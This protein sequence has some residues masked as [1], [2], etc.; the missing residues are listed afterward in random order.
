MALHRRGQ[1]YHFA[2]MVGGQRY[3]GST[4]ETVLSRARQFEA[5]MMTKV[6]EQGNSAFLA[7][8]APTLHELKGRFLEYVDNSNRLEGK[9]CQYYRHGMALLDGQPILQMRIDRITTEDIE[10]IR[11][12]GSPSNLN[13]ALRSLRRALNLA[14]N[15]RLLAKA[16]RIHLVEENRRS[17]M[18]EPD[19]EE[20]LMFALGKTGRIA[21][22]M[23]LDSGIRPNE[24]CNLQISDISFERGTLYVRRGK[25]RKSV[26]Y[27]PISNRM[28]EAL[29][30]Q[31]GTRQ[32][33]WVFPSPRHSGQP[34]QRHALTKAFAHA[35]EAAKLPKS[36]KL[37]CGRHQFAT[38]M[39]TATGNVFLLKELMG[40]TDV[41]TLERYQ[42]P[43]IALVSGMVNTRNADRANCHKIATM[44]GG[45]M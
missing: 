17:D 31:I 28:R 21:L 41:K 2:F 15:W 26:R 13:C 35:R 7:R 4:E 29:S 6:R 43:S 18:I 39:M 10:M 37:Y 33:G 23:I 5:I 32:E 30:L 22:T 44:G 1:V 34:I 42:H 36:L 3:R 38:D 16:P 14:I 20:K 9:S 12:G 40:H 8:T 19:A 24:I 25:T 45:K 11:V 27:L